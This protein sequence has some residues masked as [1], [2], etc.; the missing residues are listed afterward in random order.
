MVRRKDKRLKM[1]F[2][3]FNPLFLQKSLRNDDAKTRNRENINERL[4]NI[5]LGDTAISV[6]VQCNLLC[7][8]Y[9]RC[10]VCVPIF[11]TF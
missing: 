8:F 6:F 5:G 7:D 11:W 4:T 10:D 3:N 9:V 2:I 1:W